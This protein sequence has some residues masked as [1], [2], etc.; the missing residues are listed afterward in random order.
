MELLLPPRAW[1]R[2]ERLENLAFYLSRERV[3]GRAIG[4]GIAERVFGLGEA[5]FLPA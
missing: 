1:W 5:K 3:G 2:D 4:K